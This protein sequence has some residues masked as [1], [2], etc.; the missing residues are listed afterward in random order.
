M[1]E[2]ADAIANLE[3]SLGRSPQDA[4]IAQALDMPLE[5]YQQL[6]GELACCRMVSIEDSDAQDGEVD[7]TPLQQLQ[8][9]D[10]RQA[11]V[12]AIQDLPEREQL[13]MSLYYDEELNLKEIGLVLGV[14]ESRVSQLHGQ[15]LARLRSRLGHWK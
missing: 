12:Q 10:Y 5:D 11:L 2:V 13:L 7:D 3:A 8:A 14:S 1:R 6:A 15:A 4:E 9:G